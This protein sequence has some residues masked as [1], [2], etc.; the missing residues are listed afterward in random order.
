MLANAAHRVADGMAVARH[1]TVR[2]GVLSAIIDY[3]IL[4]R[5]G[6]AGQTVLPREPRP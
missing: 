3:A 1:D 5:L 2:L 6:G 4:S